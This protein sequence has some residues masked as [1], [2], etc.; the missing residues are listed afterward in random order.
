MKKILCLFGVLALTLTSCSK[1]DD[2]NNSNNIV[3]PKTIQFTNLKDLSKNTLSTFTYNGNKIV[4]VSNAG[5]KSEFTYT[6]NQI[7]KKVDYVMSNGQL[8]K[9]IEAS[10]VYANGKLQSVSGISYGRAF[11]QVYTYNN[12][13]TIKKEAYTIDANGVESLSPE[14]WLL[15]I[16]NGNL[17]KFVT[18]SGTFVGTHVYD[19]DA[20]NNAFKNIL[21]F[22]LLLDQAITPSLG[23]KIY[24]SLYNIEKD[25][26]S[27][28]IDSQ[29]FTNTVDY[30]AK[31]DYNA[32]GY[33]VKQTSYN[34]D[35]TVKEV[36]DYTY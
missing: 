21:G 29:P 12:D 8:G 30:N 7:T 22:N 25:T 4:T 24:S 3:L 11:K 36:F 6:G 10:Y 1:D 35:G 34:Q 32:G 13:G 19:Y 20:K 5:A 15:T 17:T 14:S 16:A 23:Q 26:Q 28:V 31:Y 2:S 9:V 18:I 33:P 27:V